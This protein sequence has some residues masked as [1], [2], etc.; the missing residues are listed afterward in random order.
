VGRATK[1]A[2]TSS[3]AAYLGTAWM[4]KELRARDS[5]GFHGGATAA[6]ELWLAGSCEAADLA[7]GP[8]RGRARQTTSL[9]AA[10]SSMETREVAATL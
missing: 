9:P 8:Q 1:A 5:S 3:V 7:G 2:Q 4:E 10:W 6:Q